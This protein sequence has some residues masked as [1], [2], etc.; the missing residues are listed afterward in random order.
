MKASP[1]LVVIVLSLPLLLAGCTVRDRGDALDGVVSHEGSAF[2]LGR[3]TD[4]GFMTRAGVVTIDPRF[5]MVGSWHNGYRWVQDGDEIAGYFID[6]EGRQVNEQPVGDTGDYFLPLPYFAYDT[7]VVRSAPKRFVYLNCDGTLGAETYATMALGHN[8]PFGTRIAVTNGAYILETPDRRPLG[9]GVFDRI[10]DRTLKSRLI[11][12]SCQGLWG[13]VDHNGAMVVDP[14]YHAIAPIY[15]NQWSL[16]HW[17]VT[18]DGR[19]GL[20][21][22]DGK[23][24][25]PLS[26][27]EIKITEPHDGIAR[28]KVAERCGVFSLS[29]NRVMIP[30]TFEAIGETWDGVVWVMERG[31]WGLIDY[32]GK[33]LR[34]PVYDSVRILPSHASQPCW[35]VKLGDSEGVANDR[36]E[37]ILSPDHNNY[38]FKSLAP[39]FI[40]VC[41][42]L[43]WGIWS[44]PQKSYTVPR[45]FEQI[46]KVSDEGRIFGVRNK[47]KW[48]L[49]NAKTGTLL[50]GE[51]DHLDEW[52]GLVVAWRGSH[53]ALFDAEGR[54]VIPWDADLSELPAS[55]RSL[56]NGVGKVVCAGKAGLIGEDGRIALPCR[57][58][59]VGN[60]SEGLVPA[61]QEGR[62]GYVN[63]DGKW[64][65]PPRYEEAGAFLNG[66]A[67]VRQD[68]QV[69]LI[70]KGGKVRVPFRYADAG[71]VFERRFPVA[72]EKDEKRR[73][74]V[75]DLA[76]NTILPPDYDCV[77]WIDLAPGTTRYHGNPG[78][79]E[80]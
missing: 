4:V 33:V 1:S 60:L 53:A 9:E 28:F 62:W 63:L 71:Y 39:D 57:Y 61:K 14:Q 77:E 19:C 26:S 13:F 56:L 54:F 30:P 80:Y 72:V 66:F 52:Q 34:A 25:F 3:G 21:N 27:E 74:G 8:S 41:G 16:T 50:H 46:D 55:Y 76:G 20:L 31:K 11:G 17:L 40:G 70:D 35:I 79:F 37:E 59:D 78:W 12:V 15:N 47:Q 69:G 75:A 67:A 51:F 2:L 43:G 22:R 58:E 44:I 65:V 24:V 5:W 7:A 29:T 49:L 18:R 38:E 45:R 6:R 10:Y 48:S 42:P 36:G 73:W 32:Y 68:G 64:V 23:T